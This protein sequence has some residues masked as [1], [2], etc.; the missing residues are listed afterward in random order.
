MRITDKLVFILL[1]LFF[2]LPAFGDD[3]DGLNVKVENLEK[4]ID[5]ETNY[6]N[7]VGNRL[8]TLQADKKELTARVDQLNAA[9]SEKEKTIK[10][11]EVSKGNNSAAQ[12]VASVSEAGKAAAADQAL[13]RE[14]ERL[15]QELEDTVKKLSETSQTLSAKE[16]EMAELKEKLNVGAK[17]ASGEAKIDDEIVAV[18]K[19]KDGL[20]NILKDKYAEIS[21]LKEKLEEKSSRN[22]ADIEKVQKDLN[23]QLTEKDERLKK[24]QGDVERLRKD[25]E[26]K[27]S[28][29][30]ESGE[31]VAQITSLKQELNS[32][33]Q[34]R[35]K[36]EEKLNMRDSQ[37]EELKDKLSH[38]QDPVKEAKEKLREA[39]TDKSDIEDQL[40]KAK[41]RLERQD[42]EE[43]SVQKLKE[44][45]RDLEKKAKSLNNQLEDANNRISALEKDLDRKESPRAVN[46]NHEV[47][48]LQ[49]EISD[50]EKTISELERKLAAQSALLKAETKLVDSG[51]KPDERL[52]REL[53]AKEREIYSLKVVIKKAIERINALTSMPLPA[54]AGSPG[55]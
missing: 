22:N 10:D 8:G 30:E 54:E 23:G 36:I 40:N 38:S 4:A 35:K 32:G 33:E 37:I 18:K 52:K 34:E 19:E 45:K 9:L 3:D 25:L 15:Q 16:K 21:T 31:L 20:N 11:L 46:N 13:T 43:V 17:P 12:S 49:D 2:I 7:E 14:K 6:L 53:E 26:S 29:G 1:S 55:R 5:A 44:E 42:K 48:R 28:R 41:N 47:K 39:L 51:V 24:L 50:K 27:T